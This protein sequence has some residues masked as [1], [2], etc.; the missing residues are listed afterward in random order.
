MAVS[1]RCSKGVR[2]I[3]DLEFEHVLPGHGDAVV[4]DAKNRYRPTIEGEL[5]GADT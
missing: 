5:K 3:L 2:S 1:K 4:G